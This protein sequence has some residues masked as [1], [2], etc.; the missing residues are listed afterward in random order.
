MPVWT[1]GSVL[2]FGVSRGSEARPRSRVRED[3]GRCR[4]V[5][6]ARNRRSGTKR[7][8]SLCRARLDAGSRHSVPSFGD[9]FPGRDSASSVPVL[10]V[11]TGRFG[12]RDARRRPSWR[13]TRRMPVMVCPPSGGSGVFRGRYARCVRRGVRLGG[14]R[15]ATGA[16][17]PSPNRAALGACGRGPLLGADS[18]PGGAPL[19]AVVG[20]L[21]SQPVL[22]A[23]GRGR[24]V[25][26]GL[27]DPLLRTS[28]RRRSRR[29]AG[30]GPSGPAGGWSR[31]SLREEL[32]RGPR[33][34]SAVS[35]WNL[36]CGVAARRVRGG[37]AL[38]ACLE[39]SSRQGRS[40]CA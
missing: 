10:S 5:L 32:P 26:G 25:L 18:V 19:G 22:A 6:R 12:V 11:G 14:L 38:G 29:A 33:A 16:P 21:R 2:R 27:T 13:N 30:R 28:R 3:D 24:V 34:P 23:S 15:S 1:V 39:A 4:R 9:F 7:R 20:R 40:V 17:A 35:S 8:T 31:P 36:S 37:Q